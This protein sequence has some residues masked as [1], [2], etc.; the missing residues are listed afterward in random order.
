M[1]TRGMV[2]AGIL[3][4]A[5]GVGE[6]LGVPR[7]ELLY[8]AALEPDDLRDPGRRLDGEAAFA[9]VRHILERTGDRALGIRL[10]E[11]MDL[12]T[13]G[14]WGYTFLSCLSVRQAAEL[15]ARFQRLR[16]TS[17]LR[18]EVHGDWAV[19]ETS[20]EV[21]IPDDLVAIFGD[22]YFASACLHRRRWVPEAHG[23]MRVW[24]TYAEEP[25][26]Q[27][28][29]ALVGGPITFGAPV[30]RLQFPAWELDLPLTRADPHLLALAREQLERQLG[31]LAAEDAPGL[32]E[33][34]RSR[35]AARLTEGA[36]IERVAR[37]LHVSVRT[38]RRRLERLGLSFQQLLEEVR[39]A[40]AV[41]YLV[42]TEDAVEHIAQRL[43]YG[44]PSNFRRAF[45]RWTGQPPAAYRAA[46]A[47]RREGKP[48]RQAS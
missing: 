36:S 30:N 42:K 13:Q 27:E 35:L 43:G 47:P 40:R 39:R 14:F 6:R 25:H 7:S 8:V 19:L 29:R 3:D 44:D 1:S 33:Q 41:E 2:A 45:R 46:H 28:L 11:A 20:T 12:R 17:S 5:C 18:F 16:T 23:E 38:L 31:A 15:L 9:I 32:A 34:V 48:P 37:E 26:H 4:V 22:T 21:A 24:L 10:A